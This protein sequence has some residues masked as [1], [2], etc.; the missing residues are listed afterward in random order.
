M[1]W[2]VYQQSKIANAERSADRA[3]A[4]VDRYADDIAG[5]KRHVEGLSLSCRAMWDSYGIT[6][7]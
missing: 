4:K 2:D 3:E 7:I 6:Q 1:I 5:I